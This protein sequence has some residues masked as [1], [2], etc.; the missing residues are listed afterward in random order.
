MFDR[1]QLHTRTVN[2]DSGAT[3]W[4]MTYNADNYLI[5]LSDMYNRTTVIAR[6]QQN[7]PLNLTMPDGA[8]TVF[9]TYGTNDSAT[10]YLSSV[11]DPLGQVSYM[12]YTTGG[13]LRSF[14]D[15][16]GDRHAFEYDNT[17]GLLVRDIDPNGGVISLSRS[18]QRTT[19]GPRGHTVAV[20]DGNGHQ[21]AYQQQILPDGSRRNSI[22]QPSGTVTTTRSFPNGTTTWTTPDG[23]F[24]SVSRGPAPARPQ[25][26]NMNLERVTVTP[27][28]L[29][30][31]LTVNQTGNATYS[32]TSVVV[33]RKTFTKIK[34]H[35]ARSVT[36]RTPEGREAVERFDEFGR[37]IYRRHWGGTPVS[38]TYDTARNVIASMTYGSGIN[39]R[40]TN[41]SYGQYGQN[42]SKTDGVGRIWE[43]GRDVLHRQTSFLPPGGLSPTRFNY[44][45]AQRE[46]YAA[47][48]SI[49]TPSGIHAFSHDGLY[50]MTDYTPPLSGAPTIRQTFNGARKRSAVIRQKGTLTT[51]FDS[52]GRE[53][54]FVAPQ[55]NITLSRDPAT[56][57]LL[58]AMNTP[59]YSGSTQHSTVELRYRFDGTAPTRITSVVDGSTHAIHSYQRGEGS[60]LVT[61]NTTVLDSSGVSLYHQHAPYSYDQDGSVLVRGQVAVA[62]GHTD[63]GHSVRVVSDESTA[64]CA[65]YCTSAVGLLFISQYFHSGVHRRLELFNSRCQAV[66]LAGYTIYQA[67]R[68]GDPY[69][70]PEDWLPKVTLSGTVN[71][72]STYVVCSGSG[73]ACDVT[74]SALD[75]TG[76]DAVA[77]YYNG[78]A[79]DTIGELT[80]DPGQGWSV[81]G[82]SAATFE[83]TL[84]RIRTVKSPSSTFDQLEWDVVPALSSGLVDDSGLGSHTMAA[85]D[86]CDQRLAPSFY[87]G[88]EGTVTLIGV[89]TTAPTYTFNV[90][91]QQVFSN[92][93]YLN[94]ASQ[95]VSIART[96]ISGGAAGSLTTMC[97]YNLTGYLAACA[98]GGQIRERYTYDANGNIASMVLTSASGANLQTVTATYDARD[99]L[100]SWGNVAWHFDL[101]GDLLSRGADTFVYSVRSE[102]LQATVGGM[103]YFY[104]Y[105]A[106]GRRVKTTGPGSSNTS[107]VYS[108]PDKHY[109]LSHSIRAGVVTSYYYDELDF[110]YAVER[111][112]RKYYCATDQVGTPK[113]LFTTSG[114]LLAEWEH[115]AYGHVLYASNASW[116]LDIGFSGG[117]LDAATGLVTIGARDYAPTVGRFVSEDPKLFDGG[118]TNL[119]MFA[120]NDPLSR[121]D[122]SGLNSIGISASVGVT[123]G[124]GIG[125]ANGDLQFCCESNS[126]A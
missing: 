84:S 120:L 79:I 44:G 59:H 67:D 27:S 85:R 94:G 36:L 60:R 34:D 7:E 40:V 2:A 15:R 116:F 61:L 121:R 105:D 73:T 24:K 115:T 123:V 33:G 13:L 118:Q 96:G 29:R 1:R 18:H 87:D 83:N 62:H 28:G 51:V 5:G 39:G 81:N 98:E 78:Q 114:V 99:R 112:G 95:V 22:T 124:I 122:P 4:S 26:Q 75:F 63:M 126:Y 23:S 86:A 16:N 11:R 108:N 49:Q 41:Y 117:L 101:D 89:E 53:A 46:V 69:P 25:L 82:V 35:I 37:T 65:Q 42:Y 103:T 92:Q 68:G 110:L 109:L 80:G 47:A 106:Y 54:G 77:L 111:H 38:I 90:S 3:L 91:G 58:S 57:A 9:T 93:L 97:T 70:E 19:G 20:T 102:L 48:A 74:S 21:T 119:Y 104:S 17:S 76:D 125:W 43:L 100:L 14:V 10:G 64:I 45:S 32:E 8:V 12:N 56:D 72:G 6:G 30:Q 52:A 107:Y 71:A 88:T 55:F 113:R 50:H 66:N 31:S